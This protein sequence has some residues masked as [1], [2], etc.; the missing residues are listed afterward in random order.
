[1]QLVPLRNGEMSSL[2][3][4]AT[5]PQAAGPLL[6]GGGGGGGGAGASHGGGGGSGVGAGREAVGLYTLNQVDP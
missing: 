3:C 2:L 4:A 5:A 6:S 1:V